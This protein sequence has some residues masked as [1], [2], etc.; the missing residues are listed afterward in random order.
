[1]PAGYLGAFRIFSGAVRTADDLRV[2]RRSSFTAG[3]FSGTCWWMLR[4]AVCTFGEVSRSLFHFSPMIFSAG[5][6]VSGQRLCAAAAM[7]LRRK[8]VH[9]P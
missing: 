7:P 2:N 1:M 5:N 3:A 4:F 6:L 9:M 8:G